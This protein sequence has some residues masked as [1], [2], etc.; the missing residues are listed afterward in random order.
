[1]VPKNKT[2]KAQDIKK[3]TVNRYIGTMLEIKT[4]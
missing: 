4:F 1:M 3:L 2:N